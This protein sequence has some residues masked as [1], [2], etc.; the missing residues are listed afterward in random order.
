MAVQTHVDVF[1]KKRAGAMGENRW[2][3]KEK[4]RTVD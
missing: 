3:T 2:Q 1:L 4:R